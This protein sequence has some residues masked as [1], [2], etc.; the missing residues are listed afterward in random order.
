MTQKRDCDR[1]PAAL[2][3]RGALQLVPGA[4]ALGAGWAVV[5][6]ST[7]AAAGQQA[8]ELRF[9]KRKGKQLS[10]LDTISLPDDVAQAI[11]SGGAG[12][13]QFAWKLKGEKATKKLAEH[14][15]PGRDEVAKK[16]QK[17]K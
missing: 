3:R 2:T 17:K 4:L 7:T 16:R 13:L 9:Y 12:G 10:L 11:D 8:Y 5:V 6:E 15:A 14:P 1:S